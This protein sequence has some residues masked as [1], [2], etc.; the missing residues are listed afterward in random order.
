[1]IQHPVMMT[2]TIT[3]GSH[4]GALSSDLGLCSV[5]S[6]RTVA[7]GSDTSCGVQEVPL[8]FVLESNATMGAMVL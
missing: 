8:P 3:A 2:A 5:A 4:F 6:A 7:A 1:M